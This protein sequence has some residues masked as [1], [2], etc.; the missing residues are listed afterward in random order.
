[1]IS[2]NT[3]YFILEWLVYILVILLVLEFIV[4]ILNHNIPLKYCEIFFAKMVFLEF[5]CIFALWCIGLFGGNCIP[6]YII[7][8]NWNYMKV[9]SID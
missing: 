5:I 1:M 4:S 9:D 3:G 8:L 7:R 6:C 2:N